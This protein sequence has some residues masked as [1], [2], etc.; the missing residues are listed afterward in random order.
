MMLVVIIAAMVPIGMDFCASLRSPERLEPAIIPGEG[1][2]T[3]CYN[4]DS[5][6]V[7]TVLVLPQV[8]AVLR[9]P[10]DDPLT[11]H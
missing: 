6:V 8:Q 2:P 10:Y 3:R 5:V 4:R 1:K 7:P 9:L 11:S